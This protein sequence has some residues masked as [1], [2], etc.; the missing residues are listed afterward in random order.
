MQKILDR[1][2]QQLGQRQQQGNLRKLPGELPRL[3]FASND[4]LGLARSQRLAEAILQAGEHYPGTLH[5]ASGSRMISGNLALAE[6]LERELAQY[7]RAEACLLFT[8]GY[9]A[10]QGLLS[11][12]LQRGDTVLYD[13]L[14]HACIKDGC[15][16]SPANRFSFR[17]NDLEHLRQKL[18]RA[19]GA[20]FV[21]VESVYS[22]DGDEAPLQELVQVCQEWGAGLIVDEAHSTALWGPDGAGSCVAQ[23]V[24][25]AVLARVHTFGKAL[26]VHGAC[27]AG[28]EL[29]KR[30]LLNYSRTFIYTTGLPP[31]SL[32]SI[33]EAVH[34]R[35]Q[36]PELVQELFRNIGLFHILLQ[37]A[38][39]Q[40]RLL[41]SRSPIQA[42]LF[43]GNSQVRAL[44][45]A[46]QAEGF[47]VWPILAPTVPEGEE[48]LRICLHSYNK[49]TEIKGL[50][51]ALS[52]HI[53]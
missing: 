45:L 53:Q 42:V 29:L 19:S 17:H 8:S 12:L 15:R 33:R 28:G 9:A 36:H 6:A 48:R 40:Q 20:I 22:M 24:A 49:E 32:L 35:Q 7:F 23:G 30:Y 27:V 43:P 39:I 13:D 2:G 44:A 46:L 4:Y 41:P 16:L 5:G 38:G 50:V 34:Y 37:Q 11:A 31:H 18:K 25:D 52:K 1:L 14:A 10:N 26:G 21:V 3:D 47:G 51:E